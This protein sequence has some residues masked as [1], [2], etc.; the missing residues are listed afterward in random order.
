MALFAC[1]WLMWLLAVTSSELQFYIFFPA[2][3]AYAFSFSHTP[4]LV[5]PHTL[6]LYFFSSF[7]HLRIAFISHTYHM[8][9]IKYIKHHWSDNPF[10]IIDCF[11]QSDYNNQVTAVEEFKKAVRKVAS[12]S[13]SPARFWAQVIIQTN[14][15]LLEKKEIDDYWLKV[16]LEIANKMEVKQYVSAKRKIMEENS[17]ENSGSSSKKINIK[18]VESRLPVVTRNQN[19]LVL[20]NENWSGSG[21]DHTFKEETSSSSS[22]TIKNK[23]KTDYYFYLVGDGQWEYSAP[24]GGEKWIVDDL[25]ITDQFLKYRCEVLESAKNL[26][27]LSTVDQLALNFICFIGENSSKGNRMMPNIWKKMM[28]DSLK[29]FK[30][31]PVA[32]N[33]V[34]WIYKINQAMR[35]GGVNVAKDILNHWCSADKD[36]HSEIYQNIYDTL[37]KVYPS[38]YDTSDANEDTF[39]KD[40]ISPILRSYFPNDEYIT[41]E[42]A[43]GVIQ[44]SCDSR[45][46]FDDTAEGKKGDYSINTND[47]KFSQ[48]VLLVECKPPRN[49]ISGDIPKL[50]RCLK[51]CLNKMTKDGADNFDLTVCGLVCEGRQCHI[52]AADHKFHGMYRCYEIGTFFI[53]QNRHDFDVMMGLFENMNTLQEIVIKNAKLCIESIRQKQNNAKKEMIIESFDS[54]IR[55]NETQALQYLNSSSSFKLGSR[56]G[57][58]L[59]FSKY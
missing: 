44:A 56:A 34:H 13:D 52:Y 43:N 38:N 35:S 23:K 48:L 28:D 7:E 33:Q 29:S 27:V 19:K 42:G 21:S 49:S 59:D 24:E 32:M 22:S 20:E 30:I 58:K 10:D 8:A 6:F 36:R 47:G 51:D 14:F 3:L 54:P 4:F 17:G 16:D 25:D 46:R 18:E 12:W 9:F 1:D 11:K 55:I 50:A 39:V 26:D 57:K 15:A 45:R 41:S 31:M 37:L 5:F 2:P 53:P 40:T